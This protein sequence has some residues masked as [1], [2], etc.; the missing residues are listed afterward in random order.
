MRAAAVGQSTADVEHGQ[1]AL[2]TVECLSRTE[3]SLKLPTRRLRHGVELHVASEG[4]SASSVAGLP[5]VL[6]Q[7][8]YYIP[9]RHGDTAIC[10]RSDDEEAQIVIGVNAPTRL[11]L[12]W[13]A[14]QDLPSWV[15]HEFEL[16]RGSEVKVRTSHA[17]CCLP[18]IRR[19][20]RSIVCSCVVTSKL[21][22]AK[23]HMFCPAEVP[24]V[25]CSCWLSHSPIT[26]LFRMPYLCTFPLST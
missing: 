4:R 3:Q 6:K 15:G 14:L 11:Y 2:A 19:S 12:L 1:F 25:S 26:A 5:P 8:S 18:F 24:A 9:A 20:I 17:S 10:N 16:V 21:H 23:H 7:G 13:P 22:L